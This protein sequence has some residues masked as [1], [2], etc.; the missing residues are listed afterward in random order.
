MTTSPSNP[1]PR[2]GRR[3]IAAALTLVGTLVWAHALAAVAR[4]FI[5]VDASEFAPAS[6]ALTLGALLTGVAGAIGLAKPSRAALQAKVA[7]LLAAAMI[8]GMHPGTWIIALALIPAGAGMAAIGRLLERRLPADLDDLPLRHPK[9]AIAWTVIAALAVMQ[10][11]RLS[12]Y[13]TD[14][15]SDWFLSTRDPFYAKHECANAYVYAAELNR[16]GEDNVYAAEHYPGIDPEAAPVSEVIGMVP[17][18]PYQYPPQFLLLPRAALGATS[19]YGA[20]RSC[21]FALNASLC[22]AAVLALATWVGG[23]TGRI[24]GLLTPALLVSFPVLH[25]LQYGQFHFAAISLSILGLLAFQRRR[26]RLGGVL[27]ACAAFAKIFPA[28]L[29]IPL[30]LQKRWRELGWTLAAGSAITLVAWGVLGPSP[31]HAFLDYHWP[32]LADGSAFAFAEAWPEVADLLVAGNQGAQGIVDKLDALG[33]VSSNAPLAR[34][35]PKLFGLALLAVAFVAGL[36]LRTASRAQHARTWLGL[37][38]LASL[39]SAGAWAD[40]VPLTCVW[41]LAYL[42]P[43]AKGSRVIL[44]A[45]SFTA[46]MQVLLVGAVPIGGASDPQWM[47]PLSLLGALSMWLT[48]VGAQLPLLPQRETSHVVA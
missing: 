8:G 10:V 9:W 5:G 47:L 11:G 21:W 22:L 32:R 33:L 30:A 18:D 26:V 35:A 20:I 2:A 45:L 24:A 44:V 31:F 43:L 1:H 38:G 17:E 42:A 7:G 29:L 13:M 48:F 16:R 3:L 46:L 36:G 15:S 37:L 23:R 39:A 6:L 41:L 28:V 14:P 34:L 40:Y 4:T 27:L 25:N 12:T 19:D